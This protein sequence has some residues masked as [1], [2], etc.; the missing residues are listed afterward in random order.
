MT[1]IEVRGQS[2][3]ASWGWGILLVISALLVLNGVALFFISAGPSTFE[4][5]TGVPMS[6][7]RE[8]FPA[9]VDEVVGAGQNLSILLAGIGLITLMLAWEGFRR[10]SR[11]AWNT[12]WVLFGTLA[13][14]GL[15]SA[16][17][18]GR[19]DIGGLYIGLAAVT[20]VGQLLASRGLSP[21]ASEQV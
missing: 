13:V 16:L 6:E 20:L 4:R 15:K 12:L 17:L 21:Q 7:V 2:R 3:A 5:D 18:G 11:W 1:T 8:M 14:V 19:P 10:R 9:V